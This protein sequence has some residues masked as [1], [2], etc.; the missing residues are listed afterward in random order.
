MKAAFVLVAI[1]GSTF[2]ELS[3]CADT[4]FA[5]GENSEALAVSL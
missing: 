3:G 4:D 5:V 2:T 1:I